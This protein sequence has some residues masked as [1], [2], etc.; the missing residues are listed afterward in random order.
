MR[1]Q[2]DKAGELGR[3]AGLRH[4]PQSTH[5]VVPLTASAVGMRIAGRLAPLVLWHRTCSVSWEQPL[6]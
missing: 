4:W 1:G 2:N 5:M 6:Q 3:D